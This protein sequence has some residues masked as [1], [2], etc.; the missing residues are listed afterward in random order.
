MVA[1]NFCKLAGVESSPIQPNSGTL[2][3]DNSNAKRACRPRVSFR[4]SLMLLRERE[5]TKFSPTGTTYSKKTTEG[6]NQLARRAYT[7]KAVNP[8]T[9][10]HG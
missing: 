10:M 1:H 8:V 9:R 2:L 7:R 3:P 4:Q 6:K 5:F